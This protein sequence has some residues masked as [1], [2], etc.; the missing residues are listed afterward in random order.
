MNI[1]GRNRQFE[2]LGGTKSTFKK[3]GVKPI[4]ATFFKK[5]RKNLK[6]RVKL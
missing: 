2:Q 4:N 1:L 6:L 3:G 5:S